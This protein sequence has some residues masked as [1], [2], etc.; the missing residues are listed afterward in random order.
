ML[1]I[2]RSALDQ[3]IKKATL[4]YYTTTHDI[5]C[6]FFLYFG[7]EGVCHSI[8]RCEEDNLGESFS[9]SAMGD[10]GIRPPDLTPIL[11]VLFL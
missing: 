7:I 1:T 2:Y 5:F 8:P 6:F 3:P 10:L 9:P 11:Q 4:A